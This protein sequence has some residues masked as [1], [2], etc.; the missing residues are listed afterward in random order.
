MQQISREMSAWL[1]YA[2]LFAATLFCLT[3]ANAQSYSND[4]ENF[5]EWSA[6][7][8]NIHI[9]EDS[10]AHS[11]NYSCFC[12]TIHEYG[13]GAEI[14][15]EQFFPRQ[16]VNCQYGFWCKWMK[17]NGNCMIVVSIDNENGNLYWQGYPLQAFHD[18]SSDWFPVSLDMNFPM[19]HLKDSKIKLYLWN[20]DGNRIL[21]DDATLNLKPIHD[22]Y[23][24]NFI[25][26]NSEDIDFKQLTLSA[27]TQPFTYPIVNLF[28][29]ILGND[30]ITEAVARWDFAKANNDNS[31]QYISE[32]NLGKTS[33]SITNNGNEI[34]CQT[35]THFNKNCKLLR[36]AIVMPF[37]DSTFT[38]YRKNQKVD[39]LDFQN[40]Y[41]LD[42]EG[43]TIGEGKRNITTY[44]N[45]KISSV[46]FDAANRTAYFN[47]D[48]WRDHPLI[49]YPLSN[50]TSDYFQNISCKEIDGNTIIKGEF[51][52]FVGT[53]IKEMPRIM[54]VWGGYES[55][56]IFT[57]HADWTEIRTHR[58][59]L[60]GNEHITR[61][62]DAVGGF[63]Y[64]GIPVTKSV[65]F[66]NPDGITNSQTSD[67]RF[68][69]LHAT[70]K[71][72]NEFYQLLK[73]LKDIG[74]DICLHTP[75]QYTTVGNNLSK[76]LKFMA[77]E[78]GSPTWID[79]GYNNGS[80]NNREN[81][82][83]D[84]LLPD[85]Q[86]YAEKLW[87]KNNVRY[88]WN[89]YYEENRMEHLNFDGHF[90]QPY[91]GFSDAMP[92]RQI[93][94]LPNDD[95]FRLWSTPSTLE[96]NTDDQ[97]Y[98]YFEAKRLQRLVD[99]HNV[100][101]THTYP[102]WTD[103]DRAFWQYNEDSTA[104]AM[105]GFNFALQ[106]IANL[107]DEKKMLPTTIQDYLSFYE[108]LLN[109]DYKILNDNTIQLTNNGQDIK[110]LTLLSENPIQ[111][112]GKNIETRQTEEG[113]FTWFDLNKNE[114]VIIQIQ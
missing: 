87:K 42:R 80:Q 47:I 69:G 114:K 101:I 99:N 44:H 8:A 113:H 85:A 15:A 29:Y 53:E 19:D 45:T 68:P 25:F 83:C 82:V 109:V 12:D 23:L 27:D 38:I 24:P 73:S 10:T 56:F 50:D 54:P 64:F 34:I 17:I 31:V 98:Y 84:A 71:T 112:E 39:S 75:E 6:P 5:S 74:F 78:F 26:E 51:T 111:I 86:Q 21:I 76:A 11:G 48:Y 90:V 52:L 110:G 41:Y 3:N 62:E 57:E 66:N 18:G 100:F 46:Q 96:V 92:N 55:A 72:D 28:E 81:L 94:T 65:F 4:F 9:S 49:H 107:R 104:V 1:K 97:W 95:Y 105:P 60:F 40:E 32:S 89:A 106:Q 36:Q 88:L 30:T 103:P 33:L 70:I 22:S 43:F 77:N 35:E 14:N 93:T 13:F 67:G 58:A 79:H 7:W 20:P 61:P 37:I 102:A 91:D 108:S 16:S 59:V 63:V 2:A